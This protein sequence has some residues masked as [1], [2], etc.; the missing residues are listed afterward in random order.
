MAAIQID[1]IDWKLHAKGVHSFTGQYPKTFAVR[2][3]LP[4]QQTLSARG[5]LIG[6]CD[7]A[8]QQHLVSEIGDLQMT[9]R[10]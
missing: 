3:L 2:E 1:E 9:I 8:G 5:T 7:V 10:G 6:K 4:S